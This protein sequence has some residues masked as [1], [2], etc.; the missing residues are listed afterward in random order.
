MAGK[1]KTKKLSLNTK[2]LKRKS[3]AFK[4]IMAK[5]EALKAIENSKRRD[6]GSRLLRFL[7]L[8]PERE[9][10]LAS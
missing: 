9:H 5:A 4:K 8:H 2:T 7:R 1:N 3:E 6:T 10:E